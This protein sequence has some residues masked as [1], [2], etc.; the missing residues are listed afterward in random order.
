M[1]GGSHLKR[2]FLSALVLVFA[3]SSLQVS[4]A[5]TDRNAIKDRTRERGQDRDVTGKDSASTRIEGPFAKGQVLVSFKGAA[6][7]RRMSSR[8]QA[9]GQIVRRDL[10]VKHLKLVELDP[11]I[12]VRA[13]IDVYDSL[14]GV[15]FAEPN[16]IYRSSVAPNDP[17]FT[18]QWSLRNVGQSIQGTPGVDG[19][20]ISARGAWNVTIGAPDVVVAVVDT[21]VDTEHPDLQP[22]VW[23]NSIE[24]AGT[25][26]VDDDGNGFV[27]DVSGWDF[28]QQDA[29]PND[30]NSHGTHVSGIIGA[31]GD[32]SMGISGVAWDVQIMPVRVLDK[33]GF[34][35]LA[36]I[37][38]GMSYAVDNGADVVNL[39]LG[40]FQ[41]SRSESHL[42]R[43]SDET[44]FVAAA[45]N[46]GN[47]NDSSGTYPCAYARTNILCVAATDNRDKIVA[48]SNYG[49][50]SV[51]LAAPGHQILSTIPA[52]QY[53]YFSGTSMATPVVAGAAALVLDL[54]PFLTPTELRTR[55]MDSTDKLPLLWTNTVTAGRLNVNNALTTTYPPAF[56]GPLELRKDP[57]DSVSHYDIRRSG[58]TK[59]DGRYLLR[60]G[61]YGSWLSSKL[62]KPENNIYMDLDTRGDGRSDFYAWIYFKNGELVGKVQRYTRQASVTV[63][64]GA[65]TRVD[66]RS[67]KMTFKPKAISG[68]EGKIRWYASSQFKG[69]FDCPTDCWDEAPNRG[70]YQYVP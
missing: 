35:T 53:A 50:T 51:D 22:N 20:D 41:R 54:E 52:N 2:A 17:R 44:L 23:A 34:G 3:T 63:G 27:D 4:I 48:W 60:V 8:D 24:T 29:N 36:R 5:S 6:A 40:S 46:S 15:A 25:A 70:W 57:Q 55:L 12:G 37:L 64:H 66:P 45:G 69:Y 33:R 13:A 43:D 47:D 59:R 11:G 19:A 9:P 30:E 61:T 18:D 67:V 21:G 10:G 31:A 7:V 58:F 68:P 62:A 42:I 39:S 32:N 56:V 49:E 65:V 16:Y 14:P 1:Q 28:V 38:A 26:E